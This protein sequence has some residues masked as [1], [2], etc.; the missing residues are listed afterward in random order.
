MKVTNSTI[1]LFGSPTS[2]FVPHI[3]LYLLLAFYLLLLAN[4]SLPFAFSQYKVQFTIFINQ[5]SH[6][7]Y[8]KT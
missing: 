8:L 5:T 6:P 7:I 1:Q 4:C 3:S 2:Y